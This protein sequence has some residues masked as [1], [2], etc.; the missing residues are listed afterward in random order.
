M[1]DSGEVLQ[2]SGV[3]T[4]GRG[5]KARLPS[6]LCPRSDISHFVLLLDYLS[7]ADL[8]SVPFLQLT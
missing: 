2:C 6:Q 5:S 8:T 7:S 4:V 3:P 1:A